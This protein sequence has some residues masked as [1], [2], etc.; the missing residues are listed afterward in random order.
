MLPPPKQ[1]LVV[2][3]E[4]ARATN[5]QIEADRVRRARRPLKC[6]IN[7]F[8]ISCFA[9]PYFVL[10]TCCMFVLLAVSQREEPVKCPIEIHAWLYIT[11]IIY[12]F[13]L[14]GTLVLVGR[15]KK[16]GTDDKLI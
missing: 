5:E 6:S 16:L 8:L 4:N 2:F 9:S 13:C 1:H 3:N 7:T 12:F 15:I 10:L 11:Q 14:F